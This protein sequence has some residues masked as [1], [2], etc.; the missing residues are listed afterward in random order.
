[1]ASGASQ[2]AATATDAVRSTGR[3]DPAQ[4]ARF[5]DHRLRPALELLAR[6]EL[7]AGGTVPTLTYDLGCGAGEI[8]RLMAERWPE[9][10][11][12]GSDFSPEM[13]QKAAATP[14]RVR[15]EE[16]DVC[17]WTPPQAPD[18]IFSNAMLQW[19]EGHDVIF[20]RLAGMLKPGG[21]LAVQIPLS[22]DEPSHRAMRTVLA[23]LGLG[24]DSLRETLARK[25][26]ADPDY[27]YDL[28]RPL[29]R[30]LDIWVTRYMQVLQGD[31]PV[32]EFVR[33]TGLRPVLTGLGDA[34]RERFLAEYRRRLDEAYPKRAGR[35]TL[36]PFPRLF[37][38]AR[39]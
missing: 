20:P 35:E 30:D 3:W 23:D 29:V 17:T 25:W 5:G 28:L 32:L 13:L 7:A 14:S 6:A 22:W 33:S 34:E 27:Y 18:L 1:M 2:A 4:Y 8:A 10:I 16:A 36:Y 11:V 38:V 21:V 19:V 24:T 15:W 39:V 12:I 37:I 9:A 31:D 26:V